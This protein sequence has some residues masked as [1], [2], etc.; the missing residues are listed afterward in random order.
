MKLMW[1]TSGVMLGL[2]GLSVAMGSVPS[3]ITDDTAI[4]QRL[5]EIRV[6]KQGNINFDADINHLSK[7]EARYQEDLPR[8]RNPM[9]RISHQ[10]YRFTGSR[11]T[12]ARK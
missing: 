12:L 2:T 7:I 11:K 10:K 1:F 3:R 8:L 4:Y 5:S 9:K 6:P